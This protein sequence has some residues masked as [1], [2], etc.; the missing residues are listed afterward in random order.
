MQVSETVTHIKGLDVNNGAKTSLEE[1]LD[2]ISPLKIE[3]KLGAVFIQLPPS[4][5]LKEGL[6][7]F[8]NYNFFFDDTFRYAIVVGHP[9]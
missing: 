2:K 8:R 3:N 4:Y 9:S 5:Q 1:F 6:D 7:A